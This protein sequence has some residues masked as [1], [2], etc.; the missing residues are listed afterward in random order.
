L[1]F[2]TDCFFAAILI[3]VYESV[4]AITDID[5]SWT[6]FTLIIITTAIPI[7]FREL[8]S[9]SITNTGIYADAQWF[10]FNALNNYTWKTIDGEA[11]HVNLV[12]AF[13]QSN[14]LYKHFKFR[15][16]K[17]KLNVKSRDMNAL[18]NRLHH[19]N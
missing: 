15:T 5:L 17:I 16:V 19:L 10:P 3:S 14:P 9:Y 4:Y 12:L 1:S 8:H 6:Q 11:N 7:V 13:N 2:N 18:N